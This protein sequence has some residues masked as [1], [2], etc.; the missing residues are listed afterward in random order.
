[1]SKRYFTIG[2]A[3]HIDHGK[4]T[5]TKALTN[6]DTD[7][8]KEEK[9]RQISIELGFAPLYEDD[10]LQISVIDV[11]GH[12]RFIRQMIAG[13]AGI[14]LV[15]LVVA[16]EEG[17]MPQTREHLEIL[18]FLGVKNGLV[19]I[20]KI[21]RV[22]EEFI[23]LVKDDI[24][25]E[26]KGS[27]FEQSPYVLVDS[28]SRKGVDELK[29]L[30]I[31][32][33]KHQ[34]MRDIRGAFRLPI[35]QVFSVKGQGTVVR[36]T[37]YEGHVSEGQ[38][39]KV[40]PKG[41]NVKARQIQV[42]HH[43]AAEAFA[44]QRAAINL[45]GVTKEEL[46]R[47][48]VLV[49]SE[50]FIVTKTID[51]AIHVV[52][53]LDYI[54]K[55]RMPIKCHIGTAE[56]MGRIVFFDRNEI[57]DENDEVLCQL[58][59]EEEVVAKR[60]DRFIIRRPSP[61]ETIGG[62]WVIEPRGEK[63][64]FG[65]RTIEQLEKKKVGTPTERIIAALVEGKSLTLTELVTI[66]ALEKE[67]IVDELT[68]DEFIQYNKTQYTIR[69]LVET[70]QEDYTD[71]ISSYHNHNSM[72]VGINKA[73][74]FHQL[75]KD[76]PKVLLEFVLQ[77]SLENQ[78][79][80]K[81]DQF[82][83]LA[84]FVPHVPVSWQKRTD[85]MLAKLKSDGFN[86]VYF[87]EYLKTEGIPERLNNEFKHFL[88]EQQQIISLDAKHYWHGDVFQEALRKM[89]SETGTEF[90]LQEAKEILSGLARKLLVP[91]LEKLDG[92][93]LTRRVENNR[94]WNEKKDTNSS[95]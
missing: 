89:R 58:R 74:L 84:S 10:E 2:M 33:L 42:H 62:G 17:V 91:F 11:P 95:I 92:M 31:E 94:V 53:D 6:I 55:Q 49:S 64:K 87:E 85:N 24:F 90:T 57:E 50:H 5:L 32:T 19:A 30:I 80:K 40:M 70:L 34:E 83:A 12:E 51:V 48:D 3:G 21:D 4:T 82:I 66:T 79:L 20:T 27:V 46:E 35:D 77:Q 72:K 54:V 18:K 61:V 78:L 36:G 47:G 76:F 44:G 73:E 75:E 14:D 7:R 8:L 29:N 38:I 23:E 15:V 41:L 68:K 93:G 81:K 65:Y 60:G 25:T 86:V 26:L 28:I 71:R 56:V 43:Q 16:A 69:S 1:M 39:L 52:S 22:D 45:T 67:M 59:L 88:E 13:V 63:Y 37:V 9:E